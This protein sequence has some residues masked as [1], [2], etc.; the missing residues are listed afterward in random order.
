[1]RLHVMAGEPLPIAQDLERFRLPANFRGRSGFTVQMWWLVQATLFR[2]S[3]QLMYAFRRWLLRIFGARI[4]KGAII[5]PTSTF[6]YPWKV[7]IGDYSWIGDDVVLYSL[8]D[9]TIGRNVVVSQ[10]GYLCAGTHDYR[11]PTFDILG[12]PINIEDE[13]WLGA[14]VFVAPGV[15]VGRGAVVGARSSV[16]TDLPPMMICVGTPARPSRARI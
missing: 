15:T 13:A 11:S 10:K 16:Y 3:P 4:G 6:T 1:M 14:D 5:R 9:I 8:A 12:F 7:T 2:G